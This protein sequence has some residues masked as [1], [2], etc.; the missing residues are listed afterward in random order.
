M[1]N[2]RLSVDADPEENESIKE[3]SEQILKLG[4]G[5]LLEP[6]NG[7]AE[8]SIPSDMLLMDSHDPIS[9]IT[10]AIYPSLVQNL[11]EESFFKDYAILCP[12]NDVVVQ[13]GQQSHRSS[14]SGVK[15]ILQLRQNMSF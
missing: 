4:D 5:K 10:N 13:G 6:K 7:E 2:M 12:T 1:K 14:P 11:K 15:G 3:F 8:I 9:S